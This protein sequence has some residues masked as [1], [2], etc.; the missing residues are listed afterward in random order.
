MLKIVVFSDKTFVYLKAK[1]LLEGELDIYKFVWH[2]RLL[3][4]SFKI[5]P[6]LKERKMVI[7]NFYF[8]ECSNLNFQRE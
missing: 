8:K 4:N 5:Q 7:V 3:K 6:M 2:G 1:K